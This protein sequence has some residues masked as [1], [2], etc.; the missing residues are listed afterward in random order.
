MSDGQIAGIKKGATSQPGK[1]PK[2]K[3]Q[4][5]QL[6][7]AM[8]AAKPDKLGQAA[9]AVPG[10]VMTTDVSFAIATLTF[11]CLKSLP[12]PCVLDVWTTVWFSTIFCWEHLKRLQF[13]L[14]GDLARPVIFP[15]TQT[16]A[17]GRE[18]VD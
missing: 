14:T 2:W 8:L 17:V 18:Q 6:R 3:Q 9:A 7:A 16:S 10:A 5:A 15:A 11:G 13:S 12:V 1:L 4:S